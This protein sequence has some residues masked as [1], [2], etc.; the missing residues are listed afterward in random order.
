MVTERCM[1]WGSEGAVPT[2]DGVWFDS[3][4]PV[5]Q[6]PLGPT[7]AE[8]REVGGLRVTAFSAQPALRRQILG[9]AGRVGVD[10]HGCPTRPLAA[11]TAGPHDLEPSGLSVCVYSQDTGASS[12]LYSTLVSAGAARA[13]AERVAAAAPAH[14]SPCGTPSGRWV[15]LGLH[16]SG[17][18]R[19]DV[20]DLGC[21]AV[22][23]GPDGTRL[24]TA[25]SV[26][27]WATD[28]I[29]AYVNPPRAADAAL[30]QLLRAPTA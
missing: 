30:R 1:S 22:R 24:L 6:K 17:G 7:V 11:P 29:P 16:G 26:R 13:Y 21:G 12:L 14:G 5:G 19:W 10:A 2:G 23:T 25:D 3:P 4:F 20:V 8:T 27:D 28:G 15:A 18:V 9:T